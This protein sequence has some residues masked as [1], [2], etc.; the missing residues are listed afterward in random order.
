MF[1]II[2]TE[3]VT[4]IDFIV[5]KS[6]PYRELEFSRRTVTQIAKRSVSLV[7]AED[8]LL[9]KLVW[10]KDSQS[11]LNLKDAQNLIDSKTNL[12]WTYLRRWAEDLDVI[13]MLNALT[14]VPH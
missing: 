6:T 1:N 11:E 7:T 5:R 14:G 2:H 13:R 12:D 9:S 3:S 4:K 10:A 8:L